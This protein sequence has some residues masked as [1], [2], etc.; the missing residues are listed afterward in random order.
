M[1]DFI[2]STGSDTSHEWWDQVRTMLHGDL[3][4]FKTWSVVRQIPLYNPNESFAHH[5]IRE[6][7]MMLAKLKEWKGVDWS[8]LREPE[9][10]HTPESYEQIK[11]VLPWCAAEDVTTSNWVMKCLHH[12]L[13]FETIRQKSILEYDTIVE[14]G[15]GIGEVARIILDRGFQ[16]NYYIVDFPEISQLSNHYLKD[17]DK[18]F[19]VDNIEKV[20]HSGQTLLIATWSLSEVP[21]NYRDNIGSHLFGSDSLITFQGQFKD[22]S[23]A[24]YFLYKWPE[25]S[26]SYVRLKPLQFHPYDGG[27]FYLIGKGA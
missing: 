27:N 7:Q 2:Y 15:A 10:G 6:N 14:V 3:N 17:R 21:L 18:L 16:G 13:T 25:A 8:I 9:I 12:I 5:Y 11:A 19:F 20:R 23:N 22:I 1:I 4:E 24:D 26:G